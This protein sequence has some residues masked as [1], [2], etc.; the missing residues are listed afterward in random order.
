MLT[1][2][3][4]PAWLGMACGPRRLCSGARLRAHIPLT[5]QDVIARVLVARGPLMAHLL[6]LIKLLRTVADFI[7]G[8]CDL[9]LHGPR[10]SSS[11]S[12][13]TVMRSSSPEKR[14]GSHHGVAAS[15]TGAGS[16]LK[17]TTNPFPPAIPA[18]AAALA[19]SAACL[20]PPLARCAQV[21]RVDAGGAL[22]SFYLE[23]R[24]R[25]RASSATPGCAAH[26]PPPRF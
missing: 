22:K 19:V 25:S 3:L 18:L 13:P 24:G 11:R 26:R 20:T 8:G 21:M 4:A 12:Q 15:Q 17:P 10:A 7:L 9:R 1:R 2:C 23:L 5:R 16:R 6:H 14:R